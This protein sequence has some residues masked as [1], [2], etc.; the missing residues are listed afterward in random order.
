M[1]FDKI[2]ST[3]SGLIRPSLIRPSIV[4]ARNA[5]RFG[6]GYRRTASGAIR[7]LA[8]LEVGPQG[9]GKTLRP[10]VGYGSGGNAA[11]GRAVLVV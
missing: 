8:S 9:R 6:P 5:C 3:R 4:R 10:F 2:P 7:R 11:L 1:S